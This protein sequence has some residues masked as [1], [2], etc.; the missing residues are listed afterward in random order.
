MRTEATINGWFSPGDDAEVKNDLKKKYGVFLNLLYMVLLLVIAGYFLIQSIKHISLY[1]ADFFN[2][3][4]II[5]SV[6]AILYALFGLIGIYID[7][8]QFKNAEFY[9]KTC[10]IENFRGESYGKDTSWYVTVHEGDHVTEYPCKNN[11]WFSDEEIAA[12]REITIAT[13]DDVNT[14]EEISMV[15][16]LDNV[17]PDYRV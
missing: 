1:G 9:V 2:I 10:R 16:I 11:P 12:K 4:K 6:V 8:N 15:Y 17:Y 5:I 7:L 14:E 13:L 3:V